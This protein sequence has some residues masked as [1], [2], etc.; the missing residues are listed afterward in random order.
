MCQL[1]K[2]GVKNIKPETL[3]IIL[4]CDETT[5]EPALIY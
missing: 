3:W 1:A 2:T 4:N 5:L